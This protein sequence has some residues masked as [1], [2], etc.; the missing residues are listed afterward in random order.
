MLFGSNNIK[1]LT[2][3]FKMYKNNN[4][5]ERLPIEDIISGLLEV[6]NAKRYED[7]LNRIKFADDLIHQYNLEDKYPSKENLISELNEKVGNPYSRLQI[8]RANLCVGSI[9]ET[10]Y[11]NIQAESKEKFAIHA[12]QNK[13]ERQVI[14][15]KLKKTIFNVKIETLTSNLSGTYFGFAIHPQFLEHIYL[16]PYVLRDQTFSVGDIV[17]ATVKIGLDRKKRG[18][19]NFIVSKIH[20]NI[21]NSSSSTQ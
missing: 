6:S 13:Q 19:F 8:G 20:E 1:T 9:H 4:I 14:T 10:H 7:T 18:R 2:K 15:E 3:A 17:H 21:N 5:E 16:P 11:D 12:I